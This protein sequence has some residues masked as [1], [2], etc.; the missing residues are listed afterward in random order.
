MCIYIYLSIYLSLSLSLSLSLCTRYY[1]YH[2][3]PTRK[4]QRVIHPKNKK[5]WLTNNAWIDWTTMALPLHVGGLHKY[6]GTILK[7]GL[8]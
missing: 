7:F 8:I 6:P 2:I 1:N 5:G 4:N 3:A